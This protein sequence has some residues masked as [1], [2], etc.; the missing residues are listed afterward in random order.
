MTL[1]QARKLILIDQAVELHLTSGPK[2]IEQQTAFLLNLM[3][4][5]CLTSGK[6]LARTSTGFFYLGD[7]SEGRVILG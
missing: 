4:D 7:I 1:G 2:L 3:W 5:V 6:L